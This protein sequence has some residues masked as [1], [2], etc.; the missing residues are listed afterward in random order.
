MIFSLIIA[1][2]SLTLHGWSGGGFLTL[3]TPVSLGHDH[4]FTTLS[5]TTLEA[6]EKSF[7]LVYPME[8]EGVFWIEVFS[9]KMYSSHNPL[10]LR[11]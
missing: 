9:R 1:H 11:I 3:G 4:F 6:V 10:N 2:T 7:S 8:F 5:T